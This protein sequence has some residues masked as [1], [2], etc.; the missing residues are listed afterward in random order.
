MEHKSPPII[1]RPGLP[2]TTEPIILPTPMFQV[3]KRD[4]LKEKV[5]TMEE[6]LEQGIERGQWS[7]KCD[8]FL[9]TLGYVVGLGNIWR[10]PYLVS[11][12]S[13]SNNFVPRVPKR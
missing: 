10:F 7:N 1:I 8:F 12:G 3:R 11:L 4:K 2:P 6:R 5:M 13:K 9:S